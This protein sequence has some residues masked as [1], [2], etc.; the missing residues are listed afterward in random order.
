MQATTSRLKENLCVELRKKKKKKKNHS[1]SSDLHMSGLCHQARIHSE[2]ISS[3]SAGAEAPRLLGTWRVNL[4]G[5]DSALCPLRGKETA[6]PVTADSRDCCQRGPVCSSIESKG[7]TWGRGGRGG[8]E[9]GRVEENSLG[10]RGE[11]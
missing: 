3:Q 1:S 9:A 5:A 6:F 2:S 7:G 4:Q 8:G 11:N 10:G